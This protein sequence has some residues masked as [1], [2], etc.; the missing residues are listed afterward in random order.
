MGG[1]ANH[2]VTDLELCAWAY[3]Y[4][5]C[6]VLGGG[7]GGWVLICGE[8]QHVLYVVRAYM[9]GTEKLNTCFEMDPFGNRAC[10]FD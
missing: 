4:V 2:G 1:G 9:R 8:M 6:L 3:A 7:Y 10:C 5:P